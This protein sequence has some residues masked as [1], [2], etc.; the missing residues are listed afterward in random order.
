MHRFRGPWFAGFVLSKLIVKL[1]AQTYIHMEGG[2]RLPYFEH[3]PVDKEE[4][5]FYI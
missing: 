5:M 4:R 2:L 3:W 1:S